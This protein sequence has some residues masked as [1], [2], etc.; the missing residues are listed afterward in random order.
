MTIGSNA[1]KK[2][3][4]GRVRVKTVKECEEIVISPIHIHTKEE[5]QEIRKNLKMTQKVFA[6]VLG[7]AQRTI[8]QW[9]SGER[10]PSGTAHRML[11]LL[12]HDNNFL[13]KYFIVKSQNGN[14]IK[15]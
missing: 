15:R 7:V 6:Q 5:I 11:A 12:A 8:E 13:Q 9:E 2:S 10:N 14:D 4:K 3:V 1:N